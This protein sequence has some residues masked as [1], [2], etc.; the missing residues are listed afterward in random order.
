M[1]GME[2]F[3]LSLGALEVL[4]PMYARPEMLHK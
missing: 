1:F 4:S 3:M 2:Y